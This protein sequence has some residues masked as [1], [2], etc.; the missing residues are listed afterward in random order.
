MQRL[1]ANCS[2]SRLQIEAFENVQHLQRGDALAVR[3][4]LVDIV[5][6]IVRRD[7]IDP[8]GG[9]L[10]EIDFAQIAAVGLH[11][12]IDL[13]RDLAFVEGVA[14]LSRDQPQ[15]FSPGRILENFAL[16][17]GAPVAISV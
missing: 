10:F 17:R 11:E 4:Q 14:A 6:A 16:G 1:R 12:G 3:R 5:A 2:P 9:V 8:G 7:R 13:V 15:A